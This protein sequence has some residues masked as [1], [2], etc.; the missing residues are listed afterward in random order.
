MHAATAD[1]TELQTPGSGK[2]DEADEADSRPS[3]PPL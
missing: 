2:D 1:D 3:T